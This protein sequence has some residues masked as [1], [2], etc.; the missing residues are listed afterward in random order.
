MCGSKD[1]G[2]PGIDH[3]KYTL[4]PVSSLN[5]WFIFKISVLVLWPVNRK[6]TT[7]LYLPFMLSQSCLSSVIMSHYSKITHLSQT[8]SFTSVT[9][10]S[11]KK[12][13][14]HRYDI[15]CHVMISSGWVGIWQT[16]SALVN[17]IFTNFSRN[18]KYPIHSG[19]YV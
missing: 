5:Q 10:L 4:K 19:L 12:E 3:D 15:F 9:E 6:F 8:Q 17:A 1:G 13:K 11:S 14:K 16:T 18:L 7:N 2:V